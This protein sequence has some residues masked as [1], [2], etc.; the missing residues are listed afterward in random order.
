[1]WKKQFPNQN[2]STILSKS[3]DSEH[4]SEIIKKNP[5]VFKVPTILALKNKLIINNTIK[6]EAEKDPVIMALKPV[7]ISKPPINHREKSSRLLKA[8]KPLKFLCKYHQ[9]Q[10]FI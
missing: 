4:I 1:M 9:I 8:N 5:N 10:L 3:Y 6:R 2:S 7:N